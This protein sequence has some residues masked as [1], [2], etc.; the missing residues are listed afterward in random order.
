MLE[1]SKVL[2]SEALQFLVEGEADGDPNDWN[3]KSRSYVYSI[4]C[5]EPKEEETDKTRPSKLSRQDFAEI[6]LLAYKKTNAARKVVRWCVVLEWPGP[7]FHMSVNTDQAVGFGSIADWL[8]KHKRLF[9][10]F[11][12]HPNYARALLY[13]IRPTKHKPY[14][15]LDKEPLFS[16]GHKPLPEAAR[17]PTRSVKASA[18]SVLKRQYPDKA[19][20]PI[21]SK[22]DVAEE[23]KRKRRIPPEAK[24]A[25]AVRVGIVTTGDELL[26]HAED[27]ML[28][29]DDNSLTRYLAGK[30]AEKIV[31]DE[32]FKMNARKRIERTKLSK[33]QIL[34]LARKEQCVCSGEWIPSLWDLCK[35]S[36]QDPMEV[37][38]AIYDALLRGAGKGRAV[39]L[40]GDTTSGKSWI[41]DPL[42][43]IFFAHDTPD[44]LGTQKPILGFQ[45]FEIALWQ[46]FR[47][48]EKGH[49]SWTNFFKLLGG[50]V[51]T[52][53]E[54]LNQSAEHTVFKVIQ[55]MFMSS[56]TIPG[57]ERQASNQADLNALMMRYKLFLFNGTIPK[58]KLRS[59]PAC[60]CC[61]AKWVLS[62]GDFCKAKIEL[63]KQTASDAAEYEIPS[64]AEQDAQLKAMSDA[65]IARLE[66]CGPCRPN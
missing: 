38:A 55:A 4:T 12:S 52:I 36:K 37:G 48:E 22:K 46:E 40:H 1:L 41:L 54:A 49:L 24:V 53:G 61:F 34:E 10:H 30:N 2:A 62:C 23:E 58:E 11:R 21:F 25:L 39:L 18:A 51:V 33:I 19:Q 47:W 32:I 3:P 44:L 16:P 45:K 43:L 63:Q 57:F 65:A 20:G 5:Y 60:K 27:L 31:K 29:M 7:H 35:R 66:T 9:V 28:N 26:V 15:Q 42:G 56:N 13:Q 8:R 17:I 64:P 50:E 14:S 6:I 59:I